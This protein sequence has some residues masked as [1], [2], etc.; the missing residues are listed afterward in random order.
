MVKLN[1]KITGDGPKSLFFIHGWGGNLEWWNS[2]CDFFSR[3][4][5]IA[6]IDLPGHGKSDM[7]KGELSSSV[8]A[9]A[10]LE[11]VNYLSDDV[12]LVAHSMSGAYVL[13]PVLR[14]KKIRKIIMIDTLKDMDQILNFEQAEKSIFSFYRE[15]Y[16]HALEYVL[17][18]YLFSGDTPVRIREKLIGEL[19]KIKPT[20]AIE[21]LSPLYKVDVRKL[22]REISIPVRAINSDISA[23]NVVANRKYFSDYKAEVM[24][25]CGH[26]PMLEQPNEFNRILNKLIKDN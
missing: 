6:L 4:Y 7:P 15:N 8:Y 12:T 24:T 23:T 10:I 14:L 2:Q 26:Y 21:L 22:A 5:N 20:R 9:G 1:F 11:V 19:L 18:D 3:S 13:D 17:S 16:K 25:K